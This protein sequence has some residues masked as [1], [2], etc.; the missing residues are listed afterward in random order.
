[1][2]FLPFTLKEFLCLLTIIR[3]LSMVSPLGIR[4]VF[5]AFAGATFCA[6]SSPGLGPL[7]QVAYF[8]V[9]RAAG[10]TGSGRV[11]S[12]LQ[13]WTGY[14][15]HPLDALGAAVAIRFLTSLIHDPDIPNSPA[16]NTR[17]QHSI[18]EIWSY[19]FGSGMDSLP[20]G[21]NRMHAASEILSD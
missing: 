10:I 11:G 2:F 8:L 19:P 3:E 5:G 15:D 18:P 14:R 20:F 13:Q 1:M 6:A 16:S 9:S 7:K 12:K 4:R 21:K 17:K